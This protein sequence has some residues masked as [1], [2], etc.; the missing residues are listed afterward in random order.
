MMA[1]LVERIARFDGLLGAKLPDNPFVRELLDMAGRNADIESFALHARALW[2]FLFARS[3]REDDVAARFDFFDDDD[4]WH[5]AK[6]IEPR[7]LSEIHGRV[8]RSVAHLTYRGAD[9]LERRWNA[10]PVWEAFAPVLG[11]FFTAASAGRLDDA[12]RAKALAVLSETSTWRPPDA[13]AAAGTQAGLAQWPRPE[14]PPVQG[15]TALSESP[16]RDPFG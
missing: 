5:A 14:A 7:E 2:Q 1:G 9:E 4:A 16:R 6:L 12:T 15:G 3:P 10:A 11:R 8:G 13:D